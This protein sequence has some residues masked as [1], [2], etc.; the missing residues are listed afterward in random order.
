MIKRDLGL[1]V[2]IPFCLKKCDY[3]DFLSGPGTNEEQAYYFRTL[4]KEIRGFE[5]LSNLYRIKSLFIGG[6]TPSSVDS[7]YI[8][9]IVDQLKSQYDFA[10]DAE[11][12]IECNPG[13]L[14]EEK[15]KT[16]RDLGI[17]RLSIG[18]QSAD[19]DELALLGRIHTFEEFTNNFALARRLGFDNIN[20]DLMSGLPGQKMSSWKNTL[21]KVVE[22]D[23]D[24]ISAYS[25]IIEEGTPFYDRYTGAGARKLPD[26]RE[27]RNMYHYTGEFLANHG[28][29]RYEISNYAKPG[30]ESRHNILYWT[31]G[32]YLGFGI[33]ASSYL[34]GK[35]FSNPKEKEEYWDYSRNAY[36][37]FRFLPV[38]EDKA[39]ME[40]FMFLGLR[41]MR[42]IQKKDFEER[43]HVPY[44]QIYGKVTEELANADMLALDE[45]RVYLTERGIDL[46]NRVLAE[47]LL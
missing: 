44:E 37:E 14:T 2:H 11:I 15:L 8:K 35:R 3:C 9:Q 20:V 46:S 4:L 7:S 12:T 30:Y 31:L 38:Q 47:F 29:D 36:N 39:T 42:G 10:E 1:Y 21:E 25:L 13:T 43:F 34:S 16:Y 28:Y 33:G 6:G 23:P 18:L 24:H 41:M 27:E 19:N 32:E 45:G 5:S 40:E 17:N 26:E 22:L